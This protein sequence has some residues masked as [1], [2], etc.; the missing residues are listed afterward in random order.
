MH[1]RRSLSVLGLLSLLVIRPELA[2]CQSLRLRELRRIP[3]DIVELSAI[4][5]VTVDSADN[6]WISQPGT[7]DIV[8]FAA[9]GTGVIR[10]GRRGEGPGDLRQV[11][12][13][14][15]TPKGLW[16]LDNLLKR[17]TVFDEAGRH[18]EV[19]SLPQLDGFSFTI[20]AAATPDG[21]TWWLARERPGPDGMGLRV[22][23]RGE[24]QARLVGRNEPDGC[25]VNARTQNRG[26]SIRAPFC[27]NQRIQ[28][29]SDGRYRATALPLPGSRDSTRARVVVMS[30]LGDTTTDIKVALPEVLI[31]ER[32]RDSTI[33]DLTASNPRGVGPGLVREILSK[34]L[35]GWH[36]PPLLDL[37][38]SGD[39]A[40][41]LTTRRDEA[42]T[43]LVLIIGRGGQRLGSFAIA[44]NKEIGWFERDRVI[45]LEADEDGLQDVVLYR[46]SPR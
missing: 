6:V 15:P 1:L 23:R 29:S 12:Q 18:K 41:A 44:A 5:L 4:G 17:A 19:T 42:G 43:K 11:Q 39:G 9:D 38:V 46:V 14:V 7:G 33:A 3:L 37:D 25:M 35:I 31:P 27:Q 34:G 20:L 21:D 13:M 45:L 30:T 24:K 16:V 40:I 28:F 26:I 36:Y 2:V 8:L 32:I 22:L 10:I